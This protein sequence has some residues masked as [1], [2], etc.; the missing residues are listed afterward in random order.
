MTTSLV[1]GPTNGTLV[2]NADGSFTYTPNANYNGTDSFTYTASDGTLTD[3]ATVNIT[4]IGIVF[5]EEKTRMFGDMYSSC[6][7]GDQHSEDT[8]EEGAK[9]VS[10][11]EPGFL[12]ECNNQAGKTLAWYISKLKDADYI[13]GHNCIN[14]DRPI[15]LNECRRY[16][17]EVPSFRW[18]DTCIDPVYPADV[19]SKSLTKLADYY[20]ISNPFKHRALSDAYVSGELFLEGNIEETL[21]RAD[22]PIVRIS[23]GTGFEGLKY[24]R[25]YWDKDNERW[26][27]YTREAYIND[28]P[29]PVMVHHV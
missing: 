14:F 18:V 29:I 19:K 16:G 12:K 11:L 7:W 26:Y 8:Y 1:T 4:E 5:F 13:V 6:L 17:V 25:F 20:G 10:G 28:V 2:L 22:G 15:L 27:K 21:Q 23:T 24:R 9:R 3:Q